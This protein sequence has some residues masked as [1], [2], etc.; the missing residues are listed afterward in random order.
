MYYKNF[1]SRFILRKDFLRRVKGRLRIYNRRLFKNE[2]E[3]LRFLYDILNYEP[4]IVVDGGANVGF[5]THQFNTKFPKSKIISF[6][7]NLLC[8]KFWNHPTRIIHRSAVLIKDLELKKK[9]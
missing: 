2:F 4:D 5:V 8:S 1:I 3:D 7:P 9:I 6:E